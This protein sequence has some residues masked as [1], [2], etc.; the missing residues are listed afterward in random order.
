MVQEKKGYYYCEH[1]HFK[2]ETKDLAM[3][4]EEYCK[5]NNACSL[6]IIQHAVP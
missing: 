5:E 4:C 1:C 3:K 6:E 2:Y